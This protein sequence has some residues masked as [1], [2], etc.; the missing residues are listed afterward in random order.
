VVADHV[1]NNLQRLLDDGRV[2]DAISAVSAEDVADHWI[3]YHSRTPKPEDSWWA[4][5]LWLT[6]EWWQDRS[7]VRRGLR[8]LVERAD[9][10]ALGAIGA[11]PLEAFI[12]DDEADL[13]WLERMAQEDAKF[14]RA[15]SNVWMDDLPEAILRR[16]ERAA[17][18]GGGADP[19][20]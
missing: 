20:A 8:A 4:V 15:L 18:G 13:R 16:L 17:N 10:A 12:G 7:R 19:L 5:E 11:G 1:V 6:P 9:E 14:A 3:R 2:D